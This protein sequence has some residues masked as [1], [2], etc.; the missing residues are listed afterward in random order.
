MSIFLR[1]SAPEDYH[2]AL[3]DRSLLPGVDVNGTTSRRLHLEDLQRSSV[4]ATRNIRPVAERLVKG[5]RHLHNLIAGHYMQV[6]DLN[7]EMADMERKIEQGNRGRKQ[8]SAS[9]RVVTLREK[10]KLV[11]RIDEIKQDHDRLVAQTRGDITADRTTLKTFQAKKVR[12]ER[13]MQYSKQELL[14]ERPAGGGGTSFWDMLPGADAIPAAHVIP[15]PGVLVGEGGM[16]WETAGTGKVRPFSLALSLA[17]GGGASM[18]STGA[19]TDRGSR[20]PTAGGGGHGHG[21][22]SPSYSRHAHFSPGRAWGLRTERRAEERLQSTQGGGGGGG[23]GGEEEMWDQE[24]RQIELQNM[25]FTATTRE[26]SGLEQL[27]R[28]ENIAHLLNRL[29]KL[30]VTSPSELAALSEERLSNIRLPPEERRALHMA[31][32]AARQAQETESFQPKA[33]PSFTWAGGAGSPIFSPLAV[34]HSPRLRALAKSLPAP[35]SGSLG[36]SI[37]T[38]SKE[39]GEGGGSLSKTG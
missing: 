20:R 16:P 6:Q 35:L 36:M 5:T 14:R 26:R 33:D 22:S 7:A 39:R 25:A 19:V 4:A 38:W 17:S 8:V 24:E 21:A 10:A 1:N 34:I 15:K 23:R 2:K 27:L 11:L 12:V 9:Q 31:V 32:Q 13:D 18:H 3:P 30:K 28:C 29:N 37:P